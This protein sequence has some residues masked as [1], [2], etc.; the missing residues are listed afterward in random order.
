M[1]KFETTIGGRV[2]VVEFGELAKQASGA[3]LVRYGESAVLSTV[4]H[5]ESEEIR[6]FLR[7]IIWGWKNTW[8]IFTS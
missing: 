4:C 2:L 5:K 8:W 3:C 1:K 7:K 6:D